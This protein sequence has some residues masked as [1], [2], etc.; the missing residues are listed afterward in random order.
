MCIYYL[1][2]L[3]S[4]EVIFEAL[5]AYVVVILL[6]LRM[7]YKREQSLNTILTVSVSKS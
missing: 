7:M 1:A 5:E 2:L 6:F 3:R 4:A